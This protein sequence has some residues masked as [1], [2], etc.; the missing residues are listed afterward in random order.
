MKSLRVVN[1]ENEKVDILS[2][3]VSRFAYSFSKDKFVE[4]MFLLPCSDGDKIDSLTLG[5]VYNDYLFNNILDISKDDFER[6]KGLT[7]IEVKVEFISYLEYFKKQSDDYPVK[8]MLKSGSIIYD[9]DGNLK[10]LQDDY[11]LNNN[12]DNLSSRGVVEM[13]PPVQYKK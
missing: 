1:I 10:S 2:D 4:G 8:S 5:I 13:Q 9:S 12:I 11:R 7:G 6:I 3:E